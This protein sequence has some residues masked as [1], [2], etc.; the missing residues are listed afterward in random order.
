MKH[1]TEIDGL[2]AVAVLP[3]ILFHAGVPGFAGGFV[4]VDVFFVLS[5]FLITG[6][7]LREAEAGRFSLLDFYDRRA[8]RILPALFLTVLLCLP[9][10][11]AVMEPDDLRK[12]GESVAGVGLFVS[13]F[14]F[15][16]QDNYF[17]GAAEQKPLLHTWSLAVEEQFYIFFPLLLVVL[18][19]RRAAALPW[20][21]AAIALAS[22][23]AAEWGWRNAASANFYLFQG[24]AWELLAGSLCAVAARRGV[25][26]AGNGPAAM[27]GL[28]LVLVSVFAFDEKT[29]FPSL[30]ALVPVVGTGLV[31]VYGRP[32]NAAGRILSWGPMVWVGL[33][34]YSAYLLHQPLLAYARLIFPEIEPPLWVMVPLG[35]LSLPLGWL[36]WRYVEQ[37]F[38]HRGA[39]AVWP[40]L[41][42]LGVSAA[43][44]ALCV[45]LGTGLHF[46]ARAVTPLEFDHT[47][48]ELVKM[49]SQSWGLYFTNKAMRA[50]L[51]RFPDRADPA[52]RSNV[53]IVGDSHMKDL[54][55]AVLQNADALPGL[56]FRH[57][58]FNGD[59]YRRTDLLGR[60]DFDVDA[61]VDAHL[62]EFPDLARDADW[63]LLKL[64]WSW[65]TE[66]IPPLEAII[67]AYQA[68]GLKVA[69]AG[70]H[71]EFPPSSRYLRWIRNLHPD[72]D[73]TKPRI[74]ALFTAR[75]DARIDAVDARLE[76]IAARAGAA[77]IDMLPSACLGRPLLCD[78]VTAE[79]APVRYD[80]HHLTVEG[81]AL[82]GRRL[83]E[84]GAFDALLPG[85]DAGGAGDAGR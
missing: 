71:A 43:G 66:F 56:A 4:G 73:W 80:A 83:A 75:R 47:L 32:D 64:R 40:G 67:D 8:R 10:A 13:N 9:P 63:V 39:G 25:G 18:V 15:W 3:V 68:R 30:L 65:R 46:G 76:R 52:L 31:A 78:A 35:L 19:R 28:I 77:W 16:M 85:R 27:A 57:A 69:V 6:I 74:D 50:E 22:L 23:L 1:R 34:S 55:N 20:I 14:I 58:G 49:R 41:R 38:R 17:G 72:A 26:A 7:L 29:P 21:L 33:I 54:L 53:L 62:A 11:W 51:S 37:P 48:R 70:S 36:S 44:L 82:I 2:R 42:F 45:A 12:F 61:C 81:S 5:G 79:M 84:A 24:R 60:P 59:C